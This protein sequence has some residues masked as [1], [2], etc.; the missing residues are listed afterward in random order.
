MNRKP[1]FSNLLAV[2]DKQTPSRPTLF[3]FFLNDP[4]IE[5]ML[6]RASMLAGKGARRSPEEEKDYQDIKEKL[7]KKE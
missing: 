1:D 3:E 7:K 2:L 4:L 5:K 6:R